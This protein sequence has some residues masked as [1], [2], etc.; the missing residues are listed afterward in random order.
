[1]SRRKIAKYGEG[2]YLAEARPVPRVS[3]TTFIDFRPILDAMTKFVPHD[4][5]TCMVKDW[6]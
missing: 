5:F 4:P 1:M 6:E 2:K 3:H